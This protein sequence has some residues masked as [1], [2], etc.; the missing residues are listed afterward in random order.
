MNKYQI[1]FHFNY[2]FV[3]IKVNIINFHKFN[4]EFL[5]LYFNLFISYF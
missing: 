2:T 4:F 5:N 1:I 3:S